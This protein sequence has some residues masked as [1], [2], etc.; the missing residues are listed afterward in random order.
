[1]GTSLP[2]APSAPGAPGRQCSST[3]KG[4]LRSGAP[5]SSSPPRGL[6][7][8]SVSFLAPIRRP[9]ISDS[10]PRG[11]ERTTTAPGSRLKT[12]GGTSLQRE[13][14]NK[15]NLTDIGYYKHN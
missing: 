8:A 12:R 4:V 11:S 10:D 13:L 9:R 15:I 5:D 1:M 14:T 3:R 2:A 7:S 6:E